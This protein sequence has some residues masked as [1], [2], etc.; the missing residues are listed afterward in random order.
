MSP[1]DKEIEGGAGVV[2]QKYEFPGYEIAEPD[3]DDYQSAEFFQL[4]VEGV[5]DY[6]IFM[7][8]PHGYIRSWNTGAE[9][10]KG[11]TAS[12]IIGHH[13]SIFYTP[14]D[15]LAGRPEKLLSLAVTEGRV[16][17]EGWRQRKDGT[18]FWADVILTTLWTPDGKIRGFAKVT[19]DMTDRRD[20]HQA[21]EEA[22]SASR[23]KSAFLANMSHEL[24][25]PLNAIIGYAELATE[26]LEGREPVVS[27]D[28]QK[29]IFASKH[30]ISIIS[31]VLDL[32]RIEAGHLEL[33]RS[34]F[35]LLQIVREVV[36]TTRVLAERN[37]NTITISCPFAFLKCEADEVRLR[38]VLYNLISNASKFT[39]NG[40]IVVK[41]TTS[42]RETHISV[43]DTGMGMTPA[44]AGRVFDN[45]YQVSQQSKDNVQGGTGLG[46]AISKLLVEAMDGKI[47]VESTEGVGSTFTVRLPRIANVTSLVAPAIRTVQS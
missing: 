30:L 40:R 7:L 41:V 32:S 33:H 15:R 13:F 46:L 35:D 36:D 1:I 39:R 45:F 38:Q 17:D 23:A 4:L 44:H 47:S 2:P 3:G 19:R 22:V 21:M 28:I 34:E 27:E 42:N 29:I 37:G 14:E 6:A 31:D 12:E 43:S 5:S 10:H 25:T 16:E 24:R 9:R 11:Y 26:N 20:L 8:D 18:R